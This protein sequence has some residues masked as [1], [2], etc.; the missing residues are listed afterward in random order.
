MK[1]RIRHATRSLFGLTPRRRPAPVGAPPAAER[2]AGALRLGGRSAFSLGVGALMLIFIGLLVANFV[3]QI[4]Q[5]ANL[6]SRRA[7]LEAEVAQMREANATL[8]GAVEF[9]ESDVYIERVAREQLGYAREGD[10]VILPRVLPPD[11]PAEPDST[12][13]PAVPAA[14]AAPNWRLWWQALFPAE[15]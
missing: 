12:V 8:K 4:V 14:P 10:V 11:Q 5:S 2:I 7:A 6:E 13:A 15:A 1:R 3:G 9:T